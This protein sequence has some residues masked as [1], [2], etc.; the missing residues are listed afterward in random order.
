MEFY[1]EVQKQRYF[2]IQ[3]GK[4]AWYTRFWTNMLLK[5]NGKG[6]VIY[7]YA[8]EKTLEPL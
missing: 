7:K 2:Q 6:Q 5:I 1:S 8:L 4:H 3:I